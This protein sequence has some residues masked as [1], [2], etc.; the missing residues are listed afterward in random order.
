MKPTKSTKR[1]YNLITPAQ[2]AK[3]K[4]LEAIVGNGS[5]AVRQLNP[6]ILNVGDRAWSI[7]K[8]ADS[9]SS[10]EFIDEQLQQIGIDA[11][12]RVGM[13]VNS[14]DEKVATKNSHYVVDHIR[15]QAIRRSESKHLQLNIE[16]VL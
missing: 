12:N 10:V 16:A 6:D 1:Q 3:F 14:V 4:A 2:I 13:L 15:G 9:I 7:R 8:K 11:V 5:E